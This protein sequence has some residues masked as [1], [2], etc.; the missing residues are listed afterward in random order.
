DLRNAPTVTLVLWKARLIRWLKENIEEYVMGSQPTTTA[1]GGLFRDH[2]SNSC[3]PSAKNF[4]RVSVLYVQIFAI[5]MAMEIASRRGGNY[6]WIESDS[7]T[8]LSAF[9]LPNIIPWYLRNCWCNCL[10]LGL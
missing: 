9:E 7:T 4:G 3:G 2:I 8:S 1:W 5:I 10:M 6:L